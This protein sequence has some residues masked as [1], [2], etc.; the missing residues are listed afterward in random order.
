[1]AIQKMK[2]IFISAT[3]SGYGA[4]NALSDLVT[5]LPEE[6]QPIVILP[7]EGPL[8]ETFR[9]ANIQTRI[10]PV[11]V[12]HRHFFHPLWIFRYLISALISIFILVR[13]F[14]ELRPD[15]IH[16]NNVLIIPSAIAACILRIPH[17]WH[18]REIICKY[19]IHPALWRCWR[20]IIETFSTRIICISEAVRAQ[21]KELQKTVVV[22]DSVDV[23]LF[24][25]VASSYQTRSD[26]IRTFRVGMLGRLE[27]RRKGQDL[28]L[29]AAREVLT[30][31]KNVRFIVA[32]DERPSMDQKEK[33]VYD[34][35]K[36][37]QMEE[38]VEF[39]GYVTREH[40][41]D[42]LNTLDVLVLYSKY[43]EGLGL[44][45]LEAMACGKAVI[46]PAEGGPLDVIEHRKTGLL[47]EPRNPE[48]LAAAIIDLFRDDLKRIE[49]G[50]QA[51]KHVEEYFS[52]EYQ[53]PKILK[54]YRE[55]LG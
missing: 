24:S 18:I 25:P 49:I 6:I 10:V 50:A 26:K 34:L 13:I 37:L 35:V 47:V 2:I 31:I 48:A 44:V 32:G 54:C 39:L 22:H 45:L 7:E 11:A 8:L 28:F 55:V 42:F 51:R 17:C 15:I 38:Y 3:A 27:H 52:I 41:P 46:A 1:M 33:K 40:L 14:K 12:L 30:E 29:V 53:I 19:H 23:R 16:T 5:N 4:E 21:F 36:E 43:P 20:W 9:K